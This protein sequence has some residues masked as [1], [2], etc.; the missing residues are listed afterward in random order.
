M[1]L[2]STVKLIIA[3]LKGDDVEATAIKI[4][5]RAESVLTAELANYAYRRHTLTDA[6]EKAEERAKDALMNN[7]QENVVRE[8]YISNILFAENAITIAKEALEQH[9]EEVKLIERKLKEL[10]AD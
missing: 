9:D 1:K 8:D 6:L 3:K 5:S 2:K 7:C 4:V 10:Q